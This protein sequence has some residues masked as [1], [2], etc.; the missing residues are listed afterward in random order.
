MRALFALCAFAVASSAFAFGVKNND[1]REYRVVFKSEKEET[2]KLIS[3][4]TNSTMVYEKHQ[5]ASYPCVLENKDTGD[6]VKLT[7]HDEKVE[8]SGGKFSVK[9]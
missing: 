3:P 8:I 4:S 2:S 5:C 9:L 1:P 7:T 6:K